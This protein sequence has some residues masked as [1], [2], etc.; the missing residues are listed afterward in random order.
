MT[1]AQ[2][3]KTD[4]DSS[5]A[6]GELNNYV[7][8]SDIIDL[9]YPVG[10]HIITNKS[11]DNPNALYSGTT[12]ELVEGYIVGYKEGD[13]DF[14]VVD[15][16]IGN[17]THTHASG[18][19]VAEI[20]AVNSNVNS[21]GYHATTPSDTITYNRGISGTSISADSITRV[22]HATTI[23]GDTSESSSLPPSTVVY[24]WKRIA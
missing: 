24:I 1:T 5:I 15:A 9:I 2:Q 23:S 20:G 16:K 18:S 7:L 19:L 10:R 8:K 22:N 14:G 21:I 12:W 3:T 4:L 6:K 11:E 17:K 13:T